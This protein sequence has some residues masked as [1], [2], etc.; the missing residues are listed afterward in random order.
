MLN[1]ARPIPRLAPVTTT[2][3]FRSRMVTLLAGD[4]RPR[5]RHLQGPNAS[6]L[7]AASSDEEADTQERKP[8]RRRRSAVGL[9]IV[10]LALGGTEV[11]RNGADKAT[12]LREFG[13]FEGG[14]EGRHGFL[15]TDRTP[16]PFCES[17]KSHAKV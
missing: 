5:R 12:V 8:G 16:L 17:H 7:Q 13:G 3:L 15:Q 9:P 11:F 4:A 2:T 1:R 6:V 10:Q 14:M